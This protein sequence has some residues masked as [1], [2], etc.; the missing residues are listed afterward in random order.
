MLLILLIITAVDGNVECWIVG[1]AGRSLCVEYTPNSLVRVTLSDESAVGIVGNWCPLPLV[2]S[3]RL[4][5]VGISRGGKV[6]GAACPMGPR[7][8][9]AMVMVLPDGGRVIYMRWLLA[10]NH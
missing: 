7:T 9:P 8:G 3:R 4:R 2:S 10:A 6:G 5:D 1:V